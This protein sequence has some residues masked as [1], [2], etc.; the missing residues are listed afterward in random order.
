MAHTSIP[1]F[2]VYESWEVCSGFSIGL[3]LST[4]PDETIVYT[5]N[6]AVS[7]SEVSE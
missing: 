2:Y 3:A 5:I 7:P 4:P 1:A 6:K